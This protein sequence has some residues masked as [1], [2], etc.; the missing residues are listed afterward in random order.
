MR[1]MWRARIPP[2][3]R[4]L[5]LQTVCRDWRYLLPT[6]V[7]GICVEPGIGR[8]ALAFSREL[9][10]SAGVTALAAC[11]LRGAVDMGGKVYVI[12]MPVNGEFSLS[13]L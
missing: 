4:S 8:N 12:T 9:P 7:L 11:L 10:N 5:Y 13:F 6:P 3:R 2:N 1:T